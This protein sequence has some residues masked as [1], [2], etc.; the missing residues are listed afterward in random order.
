MILI[1]NF[2]AS[3]PRESNKE[4]MKRDENRK[5]FKQEQVNFNPTI[6]IQITILCPFKMKMKVIRISI[7][8]AKIVD[9]KIH[10]RNCEINKN[11]IFRKI[12]VTRSVESFAKT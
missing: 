9:L 4:K 5:Q 3:H 2:I 1:E 7:L 6:S 12:V 8:L 10:I 11:E